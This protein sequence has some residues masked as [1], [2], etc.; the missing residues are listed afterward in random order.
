MSPLPS[1]LVPDADFLENDDVVGKTG[2]VCTAF[3]RNT[4]EDAVRTVKMVSKLQL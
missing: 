3:S 2:I 4:D 1:E